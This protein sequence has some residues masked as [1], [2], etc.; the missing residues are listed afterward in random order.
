MEA[1][2]TAQLVKISSLQVEIQS[3]KTLL[4]VM[5]SQTALPTTQSLI[6]LANLENS[7]QQQEMSVNHAQLGTNALLPVP[8]PVHLALTL[9]QTGLDVQQ[10]HGEKSQTAVL[11][12]FRHAQA[13][14][15]STSPQE[16]AKVVPIA[17]VARYVTKLQVIHRSVNSAN[18]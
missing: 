12:V 16:H 10:F 17:R 11:A 6:L 13:L 7:T 4:M 8:L 14:T 5:K 9:K 2:K 15:G 3:V 1:L 18:G